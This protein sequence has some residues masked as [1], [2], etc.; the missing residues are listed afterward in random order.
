MALKQILVI[1]AAVYL[2]LKINLHH[3]QSDAD[4][5]VCVVPCDDRSVMR[6]P[7]DACIDPCQGLGSFLR[8]AFTVVTVISEGGHASMPLAGFEL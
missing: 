3:L 5:S 7:R 1:T 8:G 4:P 6:S 2:C